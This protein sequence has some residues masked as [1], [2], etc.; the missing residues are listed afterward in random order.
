MYLAKSDA[1]C[2]K[3]EGPLMSALEP[4]ADVWKCGFGEPFAECLLS[5]KADL[6]T[7]SNFLG[8]G[9]PLARTTSPQ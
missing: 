9:V 6:P 5:P 3:S 8:V 7:A 4:I 1:F 2:E